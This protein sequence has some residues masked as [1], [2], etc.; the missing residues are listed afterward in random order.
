MGKYSKLIG[1]IVGG[2]IS[3]GVAVGFLPADLAEQ[4]PEIIAAIGTLG[5]AI[6]TFFAP[7]NAE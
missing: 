4:S 2:L 1:T 3:M 5:S 6:G 7:K